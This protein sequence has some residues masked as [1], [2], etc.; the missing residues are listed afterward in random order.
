M[1]TF[2]LL[3]LKGHFSEGKNTFSKES[4]SMKMQRGQTLG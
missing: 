4:K 2:D 3:G 1:G